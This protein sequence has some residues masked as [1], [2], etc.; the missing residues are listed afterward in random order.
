MKHVSFTNIF[1]TIFFLKFQNKHLVFGH[2]D[3][4]FLLTHF[5][6]DYDIFDFIKTIDILG[7]KTYQQRTTN[8]TELFCLRKSDK[9]D[10]Q[11]QM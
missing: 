7:T 10:L 11:G 1:K 2:H 3:Y 4:V 6:F 5:L 8:K 9:F